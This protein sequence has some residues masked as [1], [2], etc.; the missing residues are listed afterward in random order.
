MDRA[1]RLIELWIPHTL[2]FDELQLGRSGEGRIRFAREPLDA[3]CRASGVSP[4]LLFEGP[5]VLLPLLLKGWLS[6]LEESG[7][8]VRNHAESTAILDEML[9]EASA[10]TDLPEL[11]LFV[12]IR[13]EAVTLH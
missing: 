10:V 12:G 2:V 5:P 4:A 8:A 1:E 3:I 6:L 9:E 7:G 13:T 11:A